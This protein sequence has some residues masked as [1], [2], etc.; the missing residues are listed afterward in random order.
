MYRTAHFTQHPQT[1]VIIPE[2]IQE[3][4]FMKFIENQNFHGKHIILCVFV[5]TKCCVIWKQFQTDMIFNQNVQCLSLASYFASQ[6]EVIHNYLHHCIKWI[7]LSGQSFCKLHLIFKIFWQL[8]I[9][10]RYFDRLPL[11]FQISMKNHV[12]YIF[13]INWDMIFYQTSILDTFWG[14]FLES[15]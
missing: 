10:N 14:D 11:N 3:K 5:S 1:L 12:R 6:L 2:T 15:P 9:L 7:I 4:R 13:K 8:L